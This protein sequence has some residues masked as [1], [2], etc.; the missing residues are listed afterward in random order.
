MIRLIQLQI[1]KKARNPNVSMLFY[2]FITHNDMNAKT[3]EVNLQPKDRAKIPQIPM[4]LEMLLAVRSF[5]IYNTK[6]LIFLTYYRF[7]DQSH[8]SISHFP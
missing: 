1:S 3:Q 5:Q 4:N 7:S 8:H 2:F 6:V